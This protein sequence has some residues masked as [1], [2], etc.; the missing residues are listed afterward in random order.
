ML[1]LRVVH[2][3]LEELGRSLTSKLGWELQRVLDNRFSDP[4]MKGLQHIPRNDTHDL[5]GH[6]RL[7]ILHGW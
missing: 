1:Q 6:A 2:R 7:V 4:D 5:D 3:R